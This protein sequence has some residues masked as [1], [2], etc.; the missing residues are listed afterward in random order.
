MKSR[1]RRERI[2]SQR[3]RAQQQR[4]GGE[5]VE[6]AALHGGDLP[7]ALAGGGQAAGGRA[8]GLESLY[9]F[10][11]RRVACMASIAARVTIAIPAGSGTAA[12]DPAEMIAVGAAAV[13]A[14]PPGD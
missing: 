6:D 10:R 7:A 11:R 2:H 9:A 13:I 12:V 14:N 4:H 8:V 3:R 5:Q 1:T